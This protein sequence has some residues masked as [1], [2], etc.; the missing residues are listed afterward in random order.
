MTEYLFDEAIIDLT[1]IVEHSENKKTIIKQIMG[2]DYS[3]E[4]KDI[5]SI[6]CDITEYLENISREEFANVY[7]G[8]F[9]G[10]A[11]IEWDDD[12]ALYLRYT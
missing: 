6:G 7:N 11:R 2:D 8:L 5:E 3:C 10:E 12:K 9:R 4:G 1:I